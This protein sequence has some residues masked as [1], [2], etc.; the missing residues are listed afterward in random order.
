MSRPRLYVR[1]VGRGLVWIAPAAQREAQDIGRT[2]AHDYDP[3]PMSAAEAIAFLF[4]LY[5]VGGALWLSD[6]IRRPL[7]RS[8]R[9]G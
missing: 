8:R 6:R 9:A 4:V 7:G 2:L 3:A 5:A 1:R